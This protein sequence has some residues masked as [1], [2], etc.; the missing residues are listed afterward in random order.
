MVYIQGF[1][2]LICSSFIKCFIDNKMTVSFL[3]RRSK[4]DKC[5]QELAVLD[6][7]PFF[8][9]L[10]LKGRCK[11]CH[12]K[13]DKGIFYYELA[14]FI[15]AFI[16]I[17]TAQYRWLITYI[18]FWIVLV[19]IFIAIED[20]K[21]LEINPKL[22]L[23]LL[24]LVIVDLCLNKNFAHLG[25]SLL[26]IFFYHLFYVLLKFSIGYGDIKIFSILSIN[27]FYIDAI[28]LF[29]YTFILAGFVSIILLLLK[30]VKG[31][32]KLALAPFIALAYMFILIFREMMIW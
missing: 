16:Y 23:I 32:T 4:C 7:V 27:L 12:E 29:L 14:A 9:F 6:L 20:I 15:V 17:L 28:Y 21:T 5:H 18:D 31:K 1:L 22:Q 11:Y 3:Y 19:L 24:L 13:I 10:F 25:F 8:S 26:L 30:K 2:F